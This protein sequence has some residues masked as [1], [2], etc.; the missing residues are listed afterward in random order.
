M[1]RSATHFL[2]NSFQLFFCRTFLR[3]FENMTSVFIGS[4]AV[5]MFPRVKTAEGDR[6]FSLTVLRSVLNPLFRNVNV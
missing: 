6:K 5:L 4:K 3:F 2:C 1:A